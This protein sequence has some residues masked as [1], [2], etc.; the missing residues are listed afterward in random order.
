M[1][2]PKKIDNGTQ[3][4]TPGGRKCLSGVMSWFPGFTGIIMK[5]NLEFFSE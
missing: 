2:N 4:V 1:E 5:N 3:N